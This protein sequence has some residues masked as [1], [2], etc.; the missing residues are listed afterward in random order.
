MTDDQREGWKDQL[1]GLAGAAY[2]R[3]RRAARS[4]ERVID[5]DPYHVV[6]YRGYASATR[7]LVLGRVLQYEGIEPAQPGHSTWRNLVD[8][9]K[10][11]E[12][13]PMPFAIV[14]ARIGGTD[15]ELVAD[16]EGFLRDWVPLPGPLGAGGWQPATLELRSQSAPGKPPA[17]APILTPPG[18]A[19]FGVISDMDDT[20]LQSSVTSFL[21]AARLMLL[22]NARTRLPFPGVAAF[23]RSLVAGPAGGAG[24][25]IF[26]V[27]SSP[28]NLYDVIT[29]FLEA[30]EIPAGPLLLRD[31]DLT[32]LRERHRHHKYAHIAEI[33][34]AY[35]DLPF[36]L[37]G[38]SGQE[39]PEIYTGMVHENPGR[40][41][42]VYI[43]NVTRN[44]ERAAAIGAL[45]AEVKRAGTSL[46]LADDTLAA[47]RH[48]AEHGWIAESALGDV[49]EDKR[50]D[51][52]TSGAKVETP[53][54]E[55]EKSE[56]VVI[57]SGETRTALVE[58]SAQSSA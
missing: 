2:G 34:A 37:V 6:G 3:A 24:N 39:D 31:W 10:R 26:Y 45:A 42:A 21:R 48:A 40:I 18:S 20:V 50:A 4:I 23:Y 15:H 12:S 53:G 51:E 43:R 38:D 9:L 27:S 1:L 58:D 13:D 41:L 7:A 17:T 36:V 49:G 57:E 47:A 11:I 28:W 54:V 44:P 52:G 56:T 30:Q 46:V 16:D 19:T 14:G 8:T 22:E 5:R 55:T 32:V 29:D 35:P 25:P 33:L